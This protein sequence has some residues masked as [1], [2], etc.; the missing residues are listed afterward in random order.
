M[1]LCSLARCCRLASSPLVILTGKAIISFCKGVAEVSGGRTAGKRVFGARL[2]G[3][4]GAYITGGAGVYVVGDAGAYVV[5]DAGAY[6]VG[7][8]GA[9]VAV[10]RLLG[11]AV[12]RFTSRSI[13]VFFIFYLL[14][15]SLEILPSLL[16]S[17]S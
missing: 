15:I 17:V 1:L 6:I 10:A 3:V 7:D 2:A 13:C 5:G 16:Y 4:G 9:Q 8:A 11:V 12:T 14:K